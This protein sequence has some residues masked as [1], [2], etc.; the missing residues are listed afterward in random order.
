MSRETEQTVRVKE[1]SRLIYEK[2]KNDG[3]TLEMVADKT[4]ISP[5]TLS[6][7]ER[8]RLSDD[9][10]FEPSTKT[11]TALTQWLR[12]PVETVLGVGSQ[13]DDP[14]VLSVED[15][16][17][18]VQAHLRARKNLDSE[19]MSL[20]GEI[21]QLALQQHSNSSNQGGVSDAEN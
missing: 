8:Q 19:S 1:L 15:H 4:S 21:F 12:I 17:V 7:L 16:L 18:A 13:P 5:A 3:L 6:R 14:S 2:R 9:I 10:S 20:L 11:I